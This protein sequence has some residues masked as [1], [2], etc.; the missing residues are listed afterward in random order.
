M[1]ELLL[2]CFWQLQEPRSLVNPGH[3]T[4]MYMAVGL[5]CT[6]NKHVLGVSR[7]QG[8]EVLGQFIHQQLNNPNH[9]VNFQRVQSFLRMWPMA[10]RRS[11]HVTPCGCL[12]K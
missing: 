8:A 7:T 12:A 5:L 2:L 1:K 6:L 3:P 9:C 10:M 11:L 4:A